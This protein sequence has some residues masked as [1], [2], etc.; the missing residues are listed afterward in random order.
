MITVALAERGEAIKAKSVTA[1]NR[2][3]LLHPVM[4]IPP[5]AF[6][7]PSE[8]ISCRVWGRARPGVGADVRRFVLRL[9]PFDSRNSSTA[10]RRSAPCDNY[11]IFIY[12]YFD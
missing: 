2:P 9:S 7:P 11:G 12:S 5:D 4:Q 10:P 1:E 6:P 3:A 8:R